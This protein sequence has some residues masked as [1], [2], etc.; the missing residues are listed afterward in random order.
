MTGVG[1]GTH[2]L[3]HWVASDPTDY[4]EDRRPGRRFVTSADIGFPTFWDVA[5]AA[6]RRVAVINMP[7]TYP[8]WPV[9]G[10]MVTGLLTP[11]TVSAGWC[12]PASLASQLPE[13]RLNAS[14]IGEHRR[15][16]SAGQSCRRRC[17][18]G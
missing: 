10:T 18:P 14:S 1:P 9:N 11:D 7:L 12:Y 13:Y 17:L 6:G 8:A 3:L 2:G 4:F 15:S 5:G 16:W